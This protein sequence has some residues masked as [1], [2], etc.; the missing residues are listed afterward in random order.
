MAWVVDDTAGLGGCEPGGAGHDARVSKE[1]RKPKGG[2][3]SPQEFG[4][5]ARFADGSCSYYYFD[6]RYRDDHGKPFERWGRASQAARFPSEA[7]ARRVA[8]GM[9]TN[10]A[11]KAYDVV[12]LPPEQQKP[13]TSAPRPHP[14][15]SQRSG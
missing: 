12:P 2:G 15:G 7:D 9:Q 1:K 14:P 11:A 13:G 5:V 4:I 10:S 6:D 8:S 3:R